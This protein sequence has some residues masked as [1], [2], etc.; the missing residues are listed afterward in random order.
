MAGRALLTYAGSPSSLRE[1]PDV[2]LIDVEAVLSPPLPPA[3]ECGIERSALDINIAALDRFFDTVDRAELD[4]ACRAASSEV[5]YI[6]R[7]FT[8]PETAPTDDAPKRLGVRRN[9]AAIGL[10][11]L[12]GAAC[13][14]VPFDADGCI[15]RR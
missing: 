6:D 13:R 8:W 1:A 4:E 12:P 9:R 14:P 15:V 2:T 10:P 11:P 7:L 5:F 3:L